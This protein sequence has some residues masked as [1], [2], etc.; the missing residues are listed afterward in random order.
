MQQHLLL[1]TTS[2]TPTTRVGIA[3][4]LDATANVTDEGTITYAWYSNTT[5]SIL[6]GVPLG[7]T[8]PEYNPSESAVGTYYY[9]CIVT[10]TNAAATGT[11]IAKTSGL[12]TL[13]VTAPAIVDA[14]ALDTLVTTP[15]K[16]AVPSTTAINA[17]QYTG[18]IAWFSADGTTPVDGNF[19]A[20]TIYAA[21]VTLIAKAGY[22]LT[23]VEVNSFT[24][25]TATSVA[26]ATN[27]GI[28][29]IIFPATAAPIEITVFDPIAEVTAGVAGSAYAN[30]AAVIA[31]LPSSVTANNSTVSVPV[32]TW[33]DTDG[34][35]PDVAGSYTFTATLGAIPAGFLNTGA[36]TATVEVSVDPILVKG[37]TIS[38]PGNLNTVVNGGTLQMLVDVYPIDAT[39]KS[40]T[41]S[42]ATFADGG[43]ATI[44]ASTGELTGTS[45]G[46]GIGT[47]RVTA[48]ANDG[49]GKTDMLN[50]MVKLPSTIEFADG[51][52]ITKLTTDASFTNAVSGEGAGAITYSSGTPATA[53]VDAATGEV[54][55][56]AEGTTVITTV[57]A[58]TTTH[59]TVTNTYTLTV[60]ALSSDATLSAGS[61]G[62]A[63]LTADFNDWTSAAGGTSIGTSTGLAVSVTT[64]SNALELTKDNINSV[65]KYILIVS[66]GV[67]TGSH[68]QP[69]SDADYTSTYLPGSTNITINSS[70]DRIW[71]LVT[72][73]DGT[74]KYYWIR[75]TVSN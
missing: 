3:V 40:V 10:N 50:I 32:L 39:N 72:A 4:T 2:T 69:T 11:K 7:V 49:S 44:N 75:V 53:T 37:I 35:N 57:K 47:V 20:S 63:T 9:Y 42:V 18:T 12:F 26:N 62:G 28:V 8:T 61:L 5:A 43:E 68:P 17:D 38:S 54:T 23:G 30:A 67:G 41:W 19:E 64:G 6:E 16:Y 74:K 36:Y 51:A 56:V 45:V 73:Q 24:Y 15:V 60:A 65:V 71:M 52:T 13:T 48:T 21:K 29:T 70:F 27:A 34:Y 46:N 33:V 58:A 59:A 31:V 66:D 55:I 1:Q 25:A 14:L 22:T